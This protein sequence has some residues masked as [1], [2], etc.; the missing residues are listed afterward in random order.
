MTEHEH[1]TLTISREEPFPALEILE[2]RKS[3]RLVC[4]DLLLLTDILIDRR[5]INIYRL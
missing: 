4:K 2:S 1:A 5:A 3:T